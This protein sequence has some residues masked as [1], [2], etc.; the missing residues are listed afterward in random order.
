MQIDFYKNTVPKNRLY[1]NLT[2]HLVSQGHL[3]DPCDVLNPVIKMAYNAYHVN[4]NYCYIPDFNRYY[5]I[6]DYVIEGDTITLYMHVD[7]LYTY[8]QTI[9]QSQC[10]AMRSSSHGN[11]YLK[12]DFVQFENGWIY[13]YSKFPYEFDDETGTYLLYITGR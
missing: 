3:I 12:D 10:I 7:V 4:I 2:G 9:L 8:R 6:E 5:F 11:L 1:R 13:N